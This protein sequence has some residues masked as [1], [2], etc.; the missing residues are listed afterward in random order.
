MPVEER[1]VHGFEDIDVGKWIRVQLMFTG[2]EHVYSISG[3]SA[4]NDTDLMLTT[5]AQQRN[6]VPAQKLPIQ[7]H[8]F[9][10]LVNARWIVH[11]DLKSSFTHA[12]RC[13]I[14]LPTLG[15]TGVD[16]QCFA[17]PAYS[18]DSFQS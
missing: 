5:V 3:K 12:V 6:L 16:F 14:T 17:D 9:D 4:H 2:A 15:D 10:A 11:P 13:L 7:Y 1:L 18:Q 8:L